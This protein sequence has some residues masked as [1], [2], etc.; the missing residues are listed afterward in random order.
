MMTLTINGETHRLE[1][2]E[3]T[4]SELLD[5][6][7]LGGKP[8]VVELNRRALRPDEYPNTPVPDDSSLEIIR[9]AAGG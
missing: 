1:A 2:D 6:L 8:V 7:D 9:I 3:L 4:V 5:E